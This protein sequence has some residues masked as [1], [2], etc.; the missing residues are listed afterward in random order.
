MRKA[1][2]T[3]AR[4]MGAN[5]GDFH[6]DIVCLLRDL[7]ARLVKGNGV[8]SGGARSQLRAINRAARQVLLANHAEIS[9]YGTTTE[10]D[11]RGAE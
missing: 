10:A 3:L 2:K 5:G 7:A 1:H 6:A 8:D 9:I 11:S 4:N